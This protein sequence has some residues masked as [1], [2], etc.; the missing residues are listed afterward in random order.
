[1]KFR[2]I[3]AE[4]TVIRRAKVFEADDIDAAKEL[5][6]DDDWRTWDNFGEPETTAGIED[7]NCFEEIEQ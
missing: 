7:D 1:M 4:E 5:A 3:V 2:I 6:F